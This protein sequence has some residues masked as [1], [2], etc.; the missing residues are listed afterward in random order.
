MDLIVTTSPG[1]RQLERLQMCLR[2]LS[3]IVHDTVHIVGYQPSQELLEWLE[4]TGIH[5]V[6]TSDPK[7][8]FEQAV[9]MVRQNSDGPEGDKFIIMPDRC[10]LMSRFT[11]LRYVNIGNMYR[12]PEDQDMMARTIKY[13]LERDLESYDFELGMPAVFNKTSL[14]GLAQSVPHY[15]FNLRTLY[16]N[17]FPDR[18]MRVKNPLVEA[19]SHYLDPPDQIITVSDLAFEHDQC[20][21]FLD[22]NLPKAV[23]ENASKEE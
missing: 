8:E 12:R 14:L 6:F 9:M 21:R 5:C 17:S 1:K 15:G 23:L 4:T 19:W 2:G 13:L 22:N 16:F 18:H 7:T 3:N 10:M 20:R 11:P